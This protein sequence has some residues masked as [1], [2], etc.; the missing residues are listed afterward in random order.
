MRFAT[1]ESFQ[2]RS[3]SRGGN[4]DA[5]NFDNAKPSYDSTTNDTTY[6]DTAELDLGFIKNVDNSNAATSDIENNTMILTFRVVLEDTM[7]VKDLTNYS[8]N[9][10]MKNSEQTVW[11]GQLPFTAKVFPNRRPRLQ[12]IP[13][14]NATDNLVQG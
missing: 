4:I 2:S 11:I 5:A 7:Y 13:S 9:I 6:N 10:G 12:I 3:R 14:S 8:I 1:N